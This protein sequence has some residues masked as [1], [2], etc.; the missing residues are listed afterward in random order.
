M[1]KTSTR[2]L[3]AFGA[4]TLARLAITAYYVIVINILA[5]THYPG[6]T[7]FGPRLYPSTQCANWSLLAAQE[8]GTIMTCH[9]S[10]DWHSH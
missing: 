2:V 3:M 1:R 8:D 9:Q 4:L 5:A 7:D 6:P 10:H